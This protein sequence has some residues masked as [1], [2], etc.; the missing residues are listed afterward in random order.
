MRVPFGIGPDFQT[1][2]VAGFG[3]DELDQ[4]VGVAELAGFGHPRGQVAA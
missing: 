3:A 2:M 4:L 1:K